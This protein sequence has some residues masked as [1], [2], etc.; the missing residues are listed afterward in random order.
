MDTF[1]VEIVYLTKSW[2]AYITKN[3]NRHI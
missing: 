1:D 3:G 2:P